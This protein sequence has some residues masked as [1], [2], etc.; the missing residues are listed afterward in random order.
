MAIVNVIQLPATVLYKS[1]LDNTAS[2]SKRHLFGVR[3]PKSTN[4][5]MGGFHRPLAHGF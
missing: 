1:I 4:I 5:T 2:L 3:T